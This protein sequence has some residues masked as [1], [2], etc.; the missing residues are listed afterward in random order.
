MSLR[1]PFRELK[2]TCYLEFQ[3]HP[4]QQRCWLED[5]LFYTED[6]FDQLFSRAMAQVLPN[7]D[8]Y[9][10]IDIPRADFQRLAPELLSSP[11]GL[12]RSPKQLEEIR[13]FIQWAEERLKTETAIAFLGM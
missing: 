5:S 9:S 3:A 2:G 1:T 7:Y 4:Y 10:F 6:Q 11:P 12:P 13:F 8:Y